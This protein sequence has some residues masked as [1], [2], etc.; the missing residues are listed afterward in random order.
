MEAGPT[1]MPKPVVSNNLTYTAGY[2]HL[3]WSLL[4][5]DSFICTFLC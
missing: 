3:I 4:R 1:L 2:V 5:L